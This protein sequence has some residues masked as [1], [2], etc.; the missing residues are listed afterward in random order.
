MTG[1]DRREIGRAIAAAVAPLHDE[2]RAMRKRLAE[3]EHRGRGTLREL[4][5]GSDGETTKDIQA[6]F[7]AAH[8]A[9]A[10]E[11]EARVRPRGGS[12][13]SDPVGVSPYLRELP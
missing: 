1:C 11:A 10:A 6:A 3:L 13:G 8:E 7:D 9:D 12:S 4:F 2:L 5:G